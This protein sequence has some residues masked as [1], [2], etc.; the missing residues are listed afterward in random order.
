MDRRSAELAGRDEV[1]GWAGAQARLFAEAGLVA[2]TAF[3]SPYRIDRDRVR[4]TMADGDFIEIFV[5][6]PVEV[7]EQRDPKGLYVKARQGIIPSFTGVSAP[8][9]RPEHPDIRIDTTKVSIDDAVTLLID[10]LDQ[11]GYLLRKPGPA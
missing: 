9:E 4:A 1:R 3:I 8:Y 2:I 5:D 6:A 10:E 7:C 11:R